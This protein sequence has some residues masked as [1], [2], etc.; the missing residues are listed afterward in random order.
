MTR[1]SY[2]QSCSLARALDAIGERWTLL[3]VRDLLLEPLRYGELLD[4]L[5]G[6]GTNLLAARLRSLAGLGLVE[7]IRE[8]GRHRWGLTASGRALEPAVMEMIRWGLKTRLPGRSGESSRPEWDLI[9]MK[10]LF[11]CDA[12]DPP[13]GEYQLVLN[14]LPARLTVTDGKLGMIRGRTGEPRA[15]IEMDTATGWRI[16]TGALSDE[17]AERSGQLAIR[18]DR[19]AAK[20][21]LACF[22]MT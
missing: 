13:D 19:P 2:H 21:L 10:A 22:S 12:A 8:N 18:G 20:R 4:R 6:I 14:G 15:E 3:I 5:P 1:R 17:E 9:A 7:R 16:A 11:H